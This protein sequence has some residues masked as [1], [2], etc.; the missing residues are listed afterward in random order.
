[1]DVVVLV[2]RI[3]FTAIFLGSA[4][5]HLTKTDAMAGYAA[6]KR[7]PSPHLA[8]IVSGIYILVA[9]LMIILGLWADLAALALIPFLLIT[10]FVFHD[11]WT[12]TD[13]GARQQ[14]QIQFQ[15]DLSL[16]GAALT[17][18]ALYAATAPGLSLT[19]PLFSLG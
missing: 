17:L 14:E 3:L 11:F 9:S 13:P 8:V 19:G 7:I 4:L 16:A 6:A 2:G 1:M 10:A 12:Q 15:K 5:G 18:F